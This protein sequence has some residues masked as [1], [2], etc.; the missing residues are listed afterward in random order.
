MKLS[1][2]LQCSLKMS[3]VIVCMLGNLP[4]CAPQTPQ[5]NG[6]TIVLIRHGEKPEGGLGQLSCKGLNR[7]LAL[8]S[9]LIGRYGKPD[10]IYAPNPNVKMNDGH[11]LPTYSYLRPVATIEPTAIRLGM[12]VNTDI[13]YNQIARLQHELLQPSHA[14]SV[15]F[16]AWEHFYLHEF[17]KQMLE[18]YGS[19]GAQ[20]PD[21]PTSDYEMIYVFHVTRTGKNGSPHATLEIQREDLGETLKDTCPGPQ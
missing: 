20:A 4:F 13:G 3:L 19:N 18:S 16:V 2:F 10:Y 15:I 6:E 12:P 21:W 14:H 11:I 9:L 5:A 1:A 8:P 7:S 17:A